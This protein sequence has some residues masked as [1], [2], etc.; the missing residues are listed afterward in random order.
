MIIM[1][2]CT[3]SAI[4][5][6]LFFAVSTSAVLVDNQSFT[7]SVSERVQ[8]AYIVKLRDGFKSNNFLA[9]TRFLTDG[10]EIQ[11][12][13][14]QGTFQG[15]AGK[16]TEEQLTRLREDKRVELIEPQQ[17]V[18]ITSEQIDPPSWGLT[19]VSQRTRDLSQPYIY[20]DH[21]GEGIDVWVIDTG[22]QDNHTDFGGRAIQVKNFVTSEA[23]TDLH[24]HGTHVAGTVGSTTYGVAKKAN[25]YG[26][27]VLDSRGS[28][29]DADVIAGIQ[30]VVANGRPGKTIVN[31]SLGGSKAA[32]L[33]AALDAAVEAGFAF[34]VAAGNER[35]NA[36]YGSPSGAK[37][38]FTIAASDRNDVQASY[39][40]Y[41][42]CVNV[43][44]PGTS[45]TSLWKGSDGAVRT[46]SGTSMAAPH[47][48]GVAALY[49]ASGE[50]D[51][52][53][54]LYAALSDNATQNVI[55]R[56]SRGTPNKLIYSH[57]PEF[58]QPA[59]NERF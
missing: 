12:V 42:D 16:L 38:A 25:I 1:F 46:I 50:Y 39:S 15:F 32:T 8:D 47:V 52:V 17:I 4:S 30:Y 35:Y 9:E 36:C 23:N 53:E 21:G 2:P 33:D 22:I 56:S 6:M 59:S 7:S 54:A 3:F 27:K 49:L 45:I 19:R 40:N 51:T 55:S 57:P 58:A 41:G 28:G 5:A 26:V 31:M 29:T 37:G 10:P 34:I 20:P 43:Y 48:A 14:D 24:G 11:H 44:A 13:Y 18:H